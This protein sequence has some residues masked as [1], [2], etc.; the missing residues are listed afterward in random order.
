VRWLSTA[1]GANEPK[2]AAGDRITQPG[3]ESCRG[4]AISANVEVEVRRVSANLH[5]DEIVRH[6][7][8]G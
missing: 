1:L 7:R 3:P 2:Q 5:V 4:W 8:R 6:R